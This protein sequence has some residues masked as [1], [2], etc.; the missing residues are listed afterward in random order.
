MVSFDCS[1]GVP[2]EF[3]CLKDALIDRGFDSD[4]LAQ[5]G[6]LLTCTLGE[7]IGFFE[8]ISLARKGVQIPFYFTYRTKAFRRSSRVGFYLIDIFKPGVYVAFSQSLEDDDGEVTDSRM[9]FLTRGGR[10]LQRLR[11]SRKR[12]PYLRE[13]LVGLGADCN[14]PVNP[15]S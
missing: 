9:D 13:Q 4:L 5:D 11:K 14:R 3:I 6:N 10:R 8:G 15:S 1:D 2:R 12:R 7:N